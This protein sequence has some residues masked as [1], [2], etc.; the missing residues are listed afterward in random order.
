MQI[1]NNTALLGTAQII[2]WQN[3][4]VLEIFKK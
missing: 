1:T 4:M 3:V 2:K